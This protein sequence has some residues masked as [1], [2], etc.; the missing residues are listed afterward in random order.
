MFILSWIIAILHIVAFIL[1]FFKVF[2]ERTIEDR[3]GSF[4]AAVV[5]VVVV[6]LLMFG[7]IFR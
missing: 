5:S 1:Q 4:I 3:I 7:I 6:Y 2:T